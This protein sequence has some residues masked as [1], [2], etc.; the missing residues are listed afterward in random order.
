MGMSHAC[1]FWRGSRLAVAHIVLRILEV[2]KE[3]R[4]RVLEK[5]PPSNMAPG[6]LPTFEYKA[7]VRY[8]HN[9]YTAS[10]QTPYAQQA[11]PRVMDI[12]TT[13]EV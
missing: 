10:L 5:I 6:E 11:W 2:E 3:K 12:M 4:Q 8:A 9:V 7:S 1:Q 13:N